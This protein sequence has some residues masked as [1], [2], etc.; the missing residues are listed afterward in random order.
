MSKYNQIKQEIL[1]K[2]SQAKSEHFKRFFK[3][4]KGE[5]SE[6]DVFVG[7]SVPEQRDI[8]K[9]YFKEVSFSDLQKL[10]D[11]KCHEVRLTALLIM[12]K[13]YA[14]FADKKEDIFKLYIKNTKNINNWD[15]VDL[16]CSKIVGDY[17]FNT[18]GDLPLKTLAKSLNMWEKRIAIV[19]TMY[20]IKHGKFNLTLKFA[21]DFLKDE[22]DLTHKATGWLLREVGKA[23]CESLLKFLDKNYSVMP[24]TALRY[25]IERLPEEQRL[26]YL[27]KKP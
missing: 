18:V 3:T 12:V 7:V 22:A 11:D 9:K 14:E 19:S 24:R 5:Y 27:H 4:G 20:Y 15:L 1:S 13:I 6:N 2:G 10:L 23:D 16:T 8:A 17:C 25:A 21:K 26:Y